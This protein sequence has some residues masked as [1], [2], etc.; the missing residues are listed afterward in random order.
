MFLPERIPDLTD[1]CIGEVGVLVGLWLVRLFAGR[2]AAIDDSMLKS[3]D[4]TG[5]V[6]GS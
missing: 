2:T 1:S 5:A 6:F 4:V 3:H